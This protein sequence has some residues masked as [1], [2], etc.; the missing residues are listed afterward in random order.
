MEALLQEGPGELG[1]RA[2]CKEQ[3][4][5]A[6]PEAVLDKVGTNLLGG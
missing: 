6:V 5:E 3:P 2:G 1:E 4:I